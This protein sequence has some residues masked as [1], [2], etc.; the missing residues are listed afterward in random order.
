MSDI[1]LSEPDFVAPLA[2]LFNENQLLKADNER[3]RKLIFEVEWSPSIKGMYQCPWC[4]DSYESGAHKDDC[5][6]FRA[7]LVV[8]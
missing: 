3:L 4:E 1:K 7:P 5:P 8:R 2:K 6:A